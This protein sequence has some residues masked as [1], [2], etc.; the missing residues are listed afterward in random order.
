MNMQGH[1]SLKVYQLTFQ[2]AMKI[3]TLTKNFPKEERY[4]M[5]DQVRR[6]SRSV[7]ANIVEGYRKRQ[8]PKMFVS[9]LADLD[10]EATESIV[11]LEFA[12]AS[13]Y[14]LQIDFDELQSGYD[15][16]GRILGG[17]MAHPEKFTPRS[18]S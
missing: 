10:A 9:K 7:A 13:H 11:W 15:E 1:R 8:Y 4:S 14:L 12:I 3:F 5:T 18:H 6:S 2:L 16:V 17:M